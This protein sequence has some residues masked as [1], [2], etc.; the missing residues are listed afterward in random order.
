[1]KTNFN[2]ANSAFEY[3]YDYILE[4]G[5]EK[6]GTKYL[7]N[8]AFTIDNPLDNE[9]NASFRKWNKDYADFEWEWYLSGNNNADEIAKR[10]KIWAMCQDEN[11]CVNSNYGYQWNRGNKVSQINYIVNELTDNPQSRRAVISIYDGK[12]TELYKKDTPC[13]LSISFSIEENKLDMNVHMRSNDLV[14]GFCNDQ[15]CFSKLQ[16]L[17]ANKLNKQVGIYY[18]SVVDL[19]IYERH[20][21]MKK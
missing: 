13:T 21:N 1:M 5:K 7:K 8:I 20:F 14:F 6:C 9:I 16:E 2:N 17:V 12:E 3:L 19:H 4:N 11:G 15:Y 18:H 10:A